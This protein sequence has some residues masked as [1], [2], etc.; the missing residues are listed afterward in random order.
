MPKMNSPNEDSSKI[1]SVFFPH[2]GS[3]ESAAAAAMTC[4]EGAYSKRS[5]CVS[6]KEI[7]VVSLVCVFLCVPDIDALPDLGDALAGGCG[8][9]SNPFQDDCLKDP[10]FCL[11]EG[12]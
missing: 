4:G 11:R 2:D 6:I 12:M 7:L 5:F 3:I 10:I 1:E 9:L 8:P